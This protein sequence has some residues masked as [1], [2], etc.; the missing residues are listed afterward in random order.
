MFFF[1]LWKDMK[2]DFRLGVL[3]LGGSLPWKLS[4]RAFKIPLSNFNKKRT[5]ENILSLKLS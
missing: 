5:R 2:P 4:S 1:L 3:F